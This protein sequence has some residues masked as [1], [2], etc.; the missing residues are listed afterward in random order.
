MNIDSI[1]ACNGSIIADKV[2]NPHNVNANVCQYFIICLNLLSI[3]NIIEDIIMKN[4]KNI[5]SELNCSCEYSVL[6]SSEETFEIMNI[7]NN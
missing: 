5:A 3:M 4:G 7:P 6:N 1:N 2:M